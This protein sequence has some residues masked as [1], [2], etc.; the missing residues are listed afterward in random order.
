MSRV[1][2]FAGSDSNVATAGFAAKRWS[3][4]AQQKK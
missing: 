4:L 3:A 1:K 2:L